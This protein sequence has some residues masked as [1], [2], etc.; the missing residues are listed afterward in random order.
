LPKVLV[1]SRH[2]PPLGSAGG[3]IRLVKF[4]KY[5]SLNGW[6]FV[7]LTQDLE[8]TVVSE[9]KLSN[10][11]LDDVPIDAQIERVPAPF[12]GELESN[13]GLLFAKLKK[14]IFRAI[15]KDSSIAWGMRVFLRGAFNLN[16]WKIDLIYSVSPPF[17]DALIGSLLA[18]IGRKPY[19]L[20]LKDD[21]VGSPDFLKKNALRRKAESL[22][23]RL[24]IMSTSAIITVTP[25]SH[26]LYSK[27]YEKPGGDGKIYCVP[28]GCDLEEYKQL[29]NKQRKIETEK[30]TILSAVWGFR[31]DY[32]DL[33][34]F[35]SSLAVFLK[36]HPEAKKNVAVILLGNS[37]S[38]EYKDAIAKLGLQ[39][40]IK[41]MDAVNRQELV[42][43]MWMADMFL[44]VQPVGNTTA[45]SGTLYEHW[46]V[47]KAPVLLIS[48]KG[49]SSSLIENSNIGRHFHFSEVE[50]CAAYMEVLYLKYQSR[51]PEWI[52]RKGIEKFDRQKLAEQMENVWQKALEKS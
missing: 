36:R 4:L 38:Q 40:I 18:I 16:K 3:S 15:F 49:A 44:L 23:E 39:K 30:F 1:I 48:E 35:L 37:L 22:L 26:L 43:L 41:E 34:P 27:R 6:K 13:S 19:I 7:I 52:S 5:T 21:W 45:I 50:K 33:T 28:N 11:L 2:F 29:A 24:I 14:N 46:A 9:E 42:K 47:G 31:K 32:R 25:Q 51:N 12:R 10:S 17:T 20:D 8:K